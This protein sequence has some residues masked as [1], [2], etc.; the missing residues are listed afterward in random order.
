MELINSDILRRMQSRIV[1]KDMFDFDTLGARP[2]LS[3]LDYSDLDKLYNI[4]SSVR[5]SGNISKKLNAIRDI[6][7]NKG[8]R[9]LGQGTNRIVYSYFEDPS[10]VLKIA[11]DKV[12]MRDNPAE[13]INQNYLKPFVTKVFEVTPDGVVG[14]F[15]RVQAITS[16]EEFV[17]CSDHVYEILDIITKK[18]IM[19]DVGSHQF[20][21]W[22]IKPGF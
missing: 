2:L 12:G 5:Y 8:F 16:R 19:A 18:Y 1:S 13:F 22:G 20:F 6:M 7:H 15:E 17:S 10:I 11:T 4:A 9:K 3:M 14:E 21:N